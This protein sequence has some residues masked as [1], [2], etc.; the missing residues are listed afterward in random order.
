ME[1]ICEA[2]DL[3]LYIGPHRREASRP[4]ASGEAGPEVKVA[5]SDGAA[6]FAPQHA[7]DVQPW[8]IQMLP[9]TFGY[10]PTG[11]A[12][13]GG[14]FLAAFEL[15]PKLCRVA[16]L[17]NDSMQPPIERGS[18]LLVD[19]GRRALKPGAVYAIECDGEVLIRHARA[20][21]EAWSFVASKETLPP[22]AE[23]DAEVVGQIVWAAKL[24]G[25]GIDAADALKAMSGGQDSQLATGSG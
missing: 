19:T 17:F 10:S 15:D 25:L 8:P 1:E 11:C 2:L 24:I 20:G 7:V 6:E 22:V 14:A 3:E 4:A 21:P 12:W 18:N 13:F 23:A 5:R 9:G 16:M